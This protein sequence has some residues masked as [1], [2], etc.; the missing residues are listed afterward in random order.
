MRCAA[1]TRFATGTFTLV[2]CIENM[3]LN[4][5]LTYTKATQFG[6]VNFRGTLLRKER[7]ILGRWNSGNGDGLWKF[8]KVRARVIIMNCM[9]LWTADMSTLC[10]G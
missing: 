5:N 9:C 6:M 7:L 3:K 10:N 2:G 8:E 1:V 4:I